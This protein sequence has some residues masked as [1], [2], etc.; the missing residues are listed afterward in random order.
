[1]IFNMS[2]VPGERES[3]NHYFPQ[4]VTPTQK[5]EVYF[6]QETAGNKDP[7]NYVKKSRT[8]TFLVVQWLRIHGSVQRS[9]V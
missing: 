4:E 8:E 3:V 5:D 9:Q 6:R 7:R 2:A 1:V